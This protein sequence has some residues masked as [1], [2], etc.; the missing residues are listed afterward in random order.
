M[1]S[2]NNF[3]KYSG[4]N[5]FNTPDRCNDYDYKYFRNIPIEKIKEKKPYNQEKNKFKE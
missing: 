3:S 2:P 5:D 1:E 4:G